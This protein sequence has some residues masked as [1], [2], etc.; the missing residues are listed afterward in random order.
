MAWKK[1]GIVVGDGR[2]QTN[3]IHEAEVARACVEALD[4]GEREL[5]IGGPEVYTR[6]KLMLLA[7]EAFERPPRI[8]YVQ[9][10]LLKGPIAATRLLNR[11]I[12][13]LMAF[14]LAVSQRDVVAPK[15]GTQR[16]QDYFAG[17]IEIAARGHR[18][19]PVFR[20]VPVSTR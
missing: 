9:P 20:P 18:R 19:R 8:R 3:P 4:G 14:G 5:V 6:K 13:A 1:R 7:F 11:R 17:V 15:Y 10:G 16:I 12:G 2:A